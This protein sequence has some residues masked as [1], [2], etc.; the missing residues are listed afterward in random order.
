MNL[1]FNIVFSIRLRIGVGVN[2]VRFQEL[3]PR[4]RTAPGSIPVCALPEYVV[5]SDSN[6]WPGIRNYTF[7]ILHFLA[8]LS[9]QIIVLRIICATRSC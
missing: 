9:R 1:F 2:I 3:L 5:L 8:L 7:K 4:A 6:I